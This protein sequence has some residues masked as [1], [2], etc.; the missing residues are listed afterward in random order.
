MTLQRGDHRVEDVVRG[1]RGLEPGQPDAA[2]RASDSA[3]RRPVAIATAVL[4]IPPGP[5]IST[6]RWLCEQV[7]HGGD[8]RLAPD[9]LGRQRR[10]VPGRAV[11]AARTPSRVVVDQ[12]LSLELLQPGSGSETELVRE[13]GADPLVGRQR[14][15]LA[16]RPVQ[17]GD[18][19]LPQTFLVGVRRHGGLQLADQVAR[20]SEPQARR[21]LR[22]D[23]L[24]ACLVEPRPV[25]GG[26]VA[27][28][29]WRRSPR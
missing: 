8:L 4:P 26:P 22:L 7:R 14:I 3:S 17:R 15:G 24:H 20:P 13:Q 29:R 2:G 28:R 19:Q 12:D 27:R 6:S 9:E 11:A 16:A 5:T 25:R 10:Q 18:Q 21:E 1:R 23:Q